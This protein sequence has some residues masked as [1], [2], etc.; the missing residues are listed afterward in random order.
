MYNFKVNV[1]NPHNDGD[2]PNIPNI[3]LLNSIYYC[4]KNFIG[5]FYV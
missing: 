5:G 2:T 4:E 3:S 1:V